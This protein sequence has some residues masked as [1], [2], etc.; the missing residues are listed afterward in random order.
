MQPSWYNKEVQE[1]RI[2]HSPF[3][4]V[5]RWVFGIIIVGGIILGFMQ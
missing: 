1:V 4:K 3:V 2:Y 5:V